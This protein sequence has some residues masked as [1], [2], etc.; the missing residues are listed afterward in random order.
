MAELLFYGGIAAMS[1]AV[2]AGVV[3]LVLHRLSK[4]RLSHCLEEE[5]GKRRG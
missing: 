3:A 2:V 4:T 1:I 5:Y